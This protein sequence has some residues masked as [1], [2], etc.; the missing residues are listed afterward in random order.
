MSPLPR[1]PAARRPGAQPAGGPGLDTRTEGGAPCAHRAF[2]DAAGA[3]QAG[4]ARGGCGGWE[5]A[6]A[7]GHPPGGTLRMS[8]S[9]RS[10]ACTSSCSSQRNSSSCGDRPR[11]AARARRPRPARPPARAPHQHRPLHRRR[12]HRGRHRRRSPPSDR[13]RPA[14]PQLRQ[15]AALGPTPGRR[16]AEQERGPP[17]E[18]PPPATDW[19]R[20]L[21]LTAQ[22]NGRRSAGSQT[23]SLRLRDAV[24]TGR[25]RRALRPVS[26]APCPA[27]ARL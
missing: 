2:G 8:C 1:R 13:P 10:T 20:G 21:R 12:C 16:L 3:R 14:A 17:P 11:S 6:Q 26:S 15:F 24:S 9:C 19:P 4:A 7:R 27:P 25:R 23:R 5:R 22:R 18:A